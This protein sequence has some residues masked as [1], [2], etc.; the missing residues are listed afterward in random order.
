MPLHGLRGESGRLPATRCCSLAPSEAYSRA[1]GLERAGDN[2]GSDWGEE[3]TPVSVESTF[4][5]KSMR[6]LALEAGL[7]SLY[8]NVYQNASGVQHGEWWAL[9]EYALQRCLNPLHRFHW[10]PSAEPVGGEDPDVGEYFVSRLQHISLAVA[11]L[12]G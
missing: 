4:A 7:D 8:R 12:S 3:F 9:E 6:A 10:I 2:P 1:Y 11:H 5:G